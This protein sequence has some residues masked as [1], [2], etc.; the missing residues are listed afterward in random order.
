MND[1]IAIYL[2][3]KNVQKSC[4]IGIF[5]PAISDLGIRV[6]F[7]I[8]GL[9][10]SFGDRCGWGQISRGSRLIVVGRLHYGLNFEG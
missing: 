5:F 10:A 6:L 3:V 7:S 8:F 9:V 2:F 4:E 1:R